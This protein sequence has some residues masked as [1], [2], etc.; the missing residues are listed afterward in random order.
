MYTQACA[1]WDCCSFI[2]PTGNDAPLQPPPPPQ[3]AKRCEQVTPEHSQDCRTTPGPPWLRR[4]PAPS[5]GS[6]PISASGRQRIRVPTFSFA[7]GNSLLE[8]A[9]PFLTHCRRHD[10]CRLH[11]LCSDGS[12]TAL[13]KLRI[14]GRTIKGDPL[15]AA[16]LGQSHSAHPLELAKLAT[17]GPTRLVGLPA[18]RR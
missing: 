10:H 17:R 12:S 1:A 15:R 18:A 8:S 9:V 16:G 14:P 5:R 4:T 13:G 7:L 6:H 2:A 11:T 3:S